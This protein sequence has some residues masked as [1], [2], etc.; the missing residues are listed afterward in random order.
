[1]VILGK[2]NQFPKGKPVLP[3]SQAFTF[4]ISSGFS[5]SLKP[6]IPYKPNK[7]H[8]FDHL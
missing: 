3:S 5:S 8:F 6:H 4:L 7:I 1:M 2:T